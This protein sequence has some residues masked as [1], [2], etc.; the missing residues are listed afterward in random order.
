MRKKILSCLLCSIPILGFA[1][2]ELKTVNAIKSDS[3]FLYAM[4]VSSVSRD[5]AVKNAE[6][7]MNLAMEKWLKDVSGND[8]LECT[9]KTKDYFPRI[10][11]KKQG[12]LYRTFVFVNKQY[13]RTHGYEEVTSEDSVIQ[14]LPSEELPPTPVAETTTSTIPEGTESAYMSTSEEKN[15]LEIKTFSE[16]ND[17][18]AQGR[19]SGLIVRYG[20]YKDFHK[21]EEYY[22]FFY[23]REGEILAHIKR[24]NSKAINMDNGQLDDL[25]KYEGCGAKC[26]QLKED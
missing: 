6:E 7:K 16:L 5:E 3:S 26:I 15:M 23:N 8:T 22:L 1:Q 12:N 19:E 14:E 24:E 20:G 13:V 25:K 2:S 17:Y 9:I 10:D 11:V 18:V 4:G 21:H